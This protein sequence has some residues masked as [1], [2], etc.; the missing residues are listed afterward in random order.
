VSVDF[1]I[2]DF[3]YPLAILRLRKF[4]ERSQWFTPEEFAG[5]QNRRLRQVVEYAYRRVPYY[6]NLFRRHG[7][8]PADIR[9]GADLECV[10]P[11]TK[12]ALRR[13][14][15][16]L[17]AVGARGRVV[18]TSG[19]SDTPLRILLDKPANV[20]EFVYYWR[21]WSWAGYRLRTPFAELASSFFLNHP[22]LADRACHYQ[23]FPRRLL[24]NSLALSPDR[25]R[26]F[27]QAICHYRPQFL[28]G[29]ASALYYFACFLRDLGGMRYAFRGVFSTGE[30]L[31]PH[32]RQVIEAAFHARVYDSY[33]HM[34]RT[35]AV[36][37]CPCGGFH[38]NPEY[39]I[40][41]LVD[42][43][44]VPCP[45][46]DVSAAVRPGRFTAKILGTSLHNFAMPL[47]RYE[48]GDVAEF[49]EPENPCPCGRAM[50]RLLQILGRQEDAVVTPDGRVITTL[51]LMFAHVP[52]VIQGQF[53]QE[54][55][56]QLTVRVVPSSD[57]TVASEA[58][59][60]AGIRRF[61]G[62]AMALH[63]EYL[64]WEEWCRTSPGKFRAVVSKVHAGS[65]PGPVDP[66]PV[67]QEGP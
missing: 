13:E 35:V 28:K 53:I 43:R 16:L 37:E 30:V 22:A 1:T 31:P 3:G 33:G 6:R 36:S 48:T 47:L 21:H 4:F 17:R 25:T 51:F 38:I 9:T 32:W 40:L 39:G 27:V 10:P 60:R 20:L 57:Y 66:V 44:P 50:P 19:T 67:A 15:E 29:V 24:L 14:F 46:E 18:R 8:T 55:L 56:D 26:E 62:P 12:A 52:G 41:E 34:E 45:G 49:D 2:R 54:T 42:R 7:L 63:F 23:R 64:S 5:Y 65:R 58:A 61:V 59:L 11:L